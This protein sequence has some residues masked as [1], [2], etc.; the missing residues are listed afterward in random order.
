[1]RADESRSA[2]H[3]I[4]HPLTLFLSI[5]PGQLIDRF[6]LIANHARAAVRI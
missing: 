5:D 3:Q 2:G 6:L 4:A 1:M